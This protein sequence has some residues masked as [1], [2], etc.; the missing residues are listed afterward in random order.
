MLVL[1]TN[2]LVYASVEDSEHHRESL[3]LLGREDSVIPY[4]VVYEFLRV[5][6]ELTRDPAFVAAKVHELAEYRVVCEPLRVVQ[7][8]VELW[9]G[10]GASPSE[11]NDY[12]ILAFTAAHGAWLA[13]YDKKLS[14]LARELGVEV[15]P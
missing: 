2:V 15:I 11:L 6:A 14:K 4:I 8:G 1:D 13:T 10:H 3:K 12:I 5:I 9:S 7:H